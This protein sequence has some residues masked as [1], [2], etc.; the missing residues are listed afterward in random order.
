MISAAVQ[1]AFHPMAHPINPGNRRKAPPNE[2]GFG[3]LSIL[4]LIMVMSITL[5]V[6]T[7]K[8][9]TALKREKEKELIFIGK[10]YQQAISSYYHQSPNGL[11]ALPESMQALVS[12]T[13]FIK[14]KHH[15]RKLFLDPMTNQPWEIIRNAQ[16]KVTGVRSRSSEAF[17]MHK[18]RLSTLVEKKIVS[19]NM[20]YSD[21]KFEYQPNTNTLSAPPPRIN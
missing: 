17:Q 13:R 8:T 18:D 15:L 19:N 20:K 6:A 16:H 12:D 3:Y 9:D 2:N 1:I 4:L 21:L 14:N 5:G 11:K 10:Q 7:E